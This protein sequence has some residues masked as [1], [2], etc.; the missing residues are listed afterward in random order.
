MKE[1]KT[2]KNKKKQEKTRKNKKTKN[3]KE[4]VSKLSYIN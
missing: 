3:I 1:E 2:R 4:N